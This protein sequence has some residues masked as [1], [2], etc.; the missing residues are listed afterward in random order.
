MTIV[1]YKNCDIFL[2]FAHNI[3]YGYS[4]EPPH[5]ASDHSSDRTTESVIRLAG[6]LVDER[7]NYIVALV[8]RVFSCHIEKVFHDANMPM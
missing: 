7:I 3:D 1:T 4:F 2:I 6:C 5:W 8:R